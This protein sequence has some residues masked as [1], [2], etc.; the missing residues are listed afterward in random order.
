MKGKWVISTLFA[1]GVAPDR[2]RAL[3]D[4]GARIAYGTDL[5]NEDTKMGIDVREL[6]LLVRAGVDPVRAATSEA[7]DLLGLRDLGRLSVGS[8]AS[9]LAVRGMSPMQLAEPA[10]VMNCGKLMM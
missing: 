2:L 8:T 3:K 9:L 5:G 6:E 4:A 7:A 1:F 10:W